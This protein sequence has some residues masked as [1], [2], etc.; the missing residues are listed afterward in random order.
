MNWDRHRDLSRAWRER[1]LAY[2]AAINR[3]V[4]V[5][6]ADGWDAAG[7]APEDAREDLADAVLAVADEANRDGAW[8]ELREH[9]PPAHEPFAGRLR[10]L[11][12]G[13]EDVVWVDD[14]HAV[15]RVGTAWSLE[16]VVEFGIDGSYS[17]TDA[18]TVGRSPDRRWFA[19]ARE[20]EVEVRDGYRGATRA[21][22]P[23][24]RDN[25][26]LLTVQPFPDGDEVLVTREDGV[27]VLGKRGLRAIPVDAKADDD[28]PRSF[29]MIHAAMS[30]DGRLIAAGH[31]DSSHVVVSRDG[32]ALASFGPVHS[33]YPH[34]AAFSGDGTHA[35][36]NSCHF[37]NGVTSIVRVNDLPGLVREPYDEDPRLRVLDDQC[38]VYA[39][40][41][42]DDTIVLGDAYGYLRAWS[43]SGE[44]RWQLFCGSS[45]GGI[46]RSPD[47]RKLAVATAAGFLQ[48][49]DLDA[50]EPDPFQIGTAFHRERM[51]FV[52]WRDLPMLRW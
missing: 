30:P 13:I 5:G 11:A 24:P 31:Q 39:S 46:D 44:R 20:G 21:R 16:A 14:G 48:F 23:L 26:V 43:P 25:E 45:I 12:V 40:A 15:A 1:G 33:E 38:R 3:Y 41:F 9:F 42:I 47:G 49:Y 51:R 19:L 50:D 35:I 37:Y 10:D 17:A 22:L 18:T 34:H 32:R 8:K 2:V 36:F 27:F 4:A 6:L 7:E 29:D 52:R 28:D